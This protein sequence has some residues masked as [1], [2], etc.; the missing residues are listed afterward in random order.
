MKDL[1][2][3]PGTEH[4]APIIIKRQR[5]IRKNLTDAG[6]QASGKRLSD[7]PTI[8]ITLA[9]VDAMQGKAG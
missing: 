8:E 2:L 3:C 6:K 4:T 5:V 9:R 7:R 1:V